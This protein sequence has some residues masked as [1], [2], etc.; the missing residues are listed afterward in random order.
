MLREGV[1]SHSTR[2]VLEMGGPLVTDLVE[3]VLELWIVGG[4]IRGRSRLRLGMIGI[5]HRISIGLGLVVRSF[6]HVAFGLVRS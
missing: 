2:M 3:A 1:V 4:G 5:D 6:A